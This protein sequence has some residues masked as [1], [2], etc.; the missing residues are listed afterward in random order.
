MPTLAPL[1]ATLRTT[2]G[3]AAKPKGTAPTGIPN[4]TLRDVTERPEGVAAA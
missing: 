2:L 3:G 1:L 4:V